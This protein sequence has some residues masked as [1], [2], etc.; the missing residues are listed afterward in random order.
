MARPAGGWRRR[1]R[2]PGSC[3]HDGGAAK[4]L[5]SAANDVASR[6]PHSQRC[7]ERGGGWRTSDRRTHRKNKRTVNLA[8]CP[9]EAA[10]VAHTR[11][12]SGAG[13]SGARVLIDAS[14]TPRKNGGRAMSVRC[15][16]RARPHAPR[17]RFNLILRDSLGSADSAARG[18]KI[19]TREPK[20]TR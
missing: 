1:A 2:Q 20:M 16:V 3:G 18:A 14:N 4:H 8:R 12:G 10:R 13:A 9:F 6:K 17:G 15:V 5:P 19:G 11:R 7:A